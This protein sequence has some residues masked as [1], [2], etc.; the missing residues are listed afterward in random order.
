M[1][2]Y[3]GSNNYFVVVVGVVLLLLLPIKLSIKNGIKEDFTPAYSRLHI[4]L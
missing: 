3:A 4:S 2:C 1:E